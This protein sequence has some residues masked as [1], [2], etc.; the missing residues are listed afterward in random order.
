[1]D[2]PKVIPVVNTV[3]I[4]LFY[5]GF[6]SVFFA[7]VPMVI[8]VVIPVVIPMVIPVVNPVVNPVVIFRY[9]SP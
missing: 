6:N 5:K 7:F 2:I 8:P 1:M 9:T 4:M 3:V